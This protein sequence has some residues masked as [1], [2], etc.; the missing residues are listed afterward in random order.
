MVLGSWKAKGDGTA[1]A[2]YRVAVVAL[3]GV[4]CAPRIVAASQQKP[5]N[6][7]C[8]VMTQEE[9]NPEF[10]MIF[11]GRVVGFCC[12]KCLAKF[13]ANP[14]RYA[15]RLRELES[16]SPP[17]SPDHPH[18]EAGA[19][20][21]A[22]SPDKLVHGDH[23][24]AG[25]T[26]HDVTRGEFHDHDHDE[27]ERSVGANDIHRHEHGHAHGA[28]FMAKVI[29]WLG[30]FHPAMVNFPIAMTLGAA[31]AELLLIATGRSSFVNAGRFCL[32]VGSLGAILAAVLGWF[33]G[34]FHLVDDSWI[35]TTHRWLG[36]TTAVWSALALVVAERALRHAGASR[37][38]YRAM[39]FIG[40]GLVA[41]TG[42]FGGTL[43]YGLNHYAF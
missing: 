25:N 22:G 13:E 38:R 18:G 42:F 37:A 15:G 16:K 26:G 41:A 12:E 6:A 9:V 17:I 35:L 14:R 33:F 11:E 4:V 3:L 20:Q 10:T 28:G 23:V 39:L 32:W 27:G 19:N 21:P 7:S 1:A 34:G 30:K 5:V 31:L 2:A 29:G 43:I 36:T 8:P 40:A 24:H